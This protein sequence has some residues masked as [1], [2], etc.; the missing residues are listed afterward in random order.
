MGIE[1]ALVDDEAREY[2]R[3]GKKRGWREDDLRGPECVGFQMP[4]ERIVKF[5]ANC[6][7]APLR[8]VPDTGEDYDQVRERGYRLLDEWSRG[9]D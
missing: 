1:Y 9:L 8:I 4:D 5:L 3:L 2:I 6:G 7:D